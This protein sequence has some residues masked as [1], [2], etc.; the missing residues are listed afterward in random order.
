MFN[1]GTWLVMFIERASL[2]PYCRTAGKQSLFQRHKIERYLNRSVFRSGTWLVLPVCVSVV[3]SQ[4]WNKSKPSLI[5]S[6]QIYQ[7]WNQNL[8]GQDDMGKFLGSSRQSLGFE[9][10]FS[11]KWLNNIGDH[12]WIVRSLIFSW[13]PSSWPWILLANVTQVPRNIQTN[14]MTLR[15]LMCNEH[16]WLGVRWGDFS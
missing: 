1:W 4:I 6:K 16:I 2:L 9:R 7:Y 5:K 15:G 3:V 13:S 12:Q 10:N 14:S 11:K 8:L